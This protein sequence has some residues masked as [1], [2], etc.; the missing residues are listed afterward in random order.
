MNFTYEQL[1]AN[2]ISYIKSEKDIR[3]AA[4]VGSQARS[5]HLADEWADLDIVIY[6]TIPKK[7]LFNTDG[8][9]VLVRFT[10]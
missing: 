7:Y 4:V 8:C 3:A 5:D 9:Q 6:T 10:S 2:L 1:T